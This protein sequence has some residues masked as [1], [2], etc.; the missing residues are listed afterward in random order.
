MNDHSAHRSKNMNENGD[1]NCWK[2]APA[3]QPTVP[4]QDTVLCLVTT[5]RG[6]GIPLN[7]VWRSLTEKTL[8]KTGAWPPTDFS[9]SSQLACPKSSHPMMGA[10]QPGD[11]EARWERSKAG[12][13]PGP[14][15][16][17]IA[18]QVW[19]G[20]FFSPPSAV[21]NMGSKR[22]P[23]RVWNHHLHFI[24]TEKKYTYVQTQEHTVERDP[25]NNRM[26]GINYKYP[27]WVAFKKKLVRNN[28][29]TAIYIYEK[30]C[31]IQQEREKALRASNTDQNTTAVNCTQLLKQSGYA[32]GRWKD[33]PRKIKSLLWTPTWRRQKPLLKWISVLLLPLG[34]SSQLRNWT[35]P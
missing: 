11:T 20:T 25:R 1:S 29:S 30:A 14:F 4:P 9:N 22:S 28:L 7:F 24:T 26:P 19:S 15:W 6:S 34:S 35:A 8:Q 32:C 16:A 5:N 13:P 3:V 12:C 23:W 18:Q 10:W 2:T 21:V 33:P 31:Q 17:W 27:A